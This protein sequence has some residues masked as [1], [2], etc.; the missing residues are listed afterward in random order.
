MKWDVKR[1]KGVVML[2]KGRESER[3]GGV[4]SENKHENKAGDDDQ[5]EHKDCAEKTLL[6]RLLLDAAGLHGAL[7][8]LHAC[9]V[10]VAV[11]VVQK[12]VLVL[13]LVVHVGC[14]VV[15][16]PHARRNALEAVVLLCNLVLRRR[17][18]CARVGR[19]CACSPGS[20]SCA[21][22]VELKV[23]AQAEIVLQEV[24]KRQKKKQE[25][26]VSQNTNKLEKCFVLFPSRHKKGRRA[27]LETEMYM[28]R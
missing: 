10:D 24:G 8:D 25:K 23:F 2:E 3:W 16:D 9:G 7:A 14:N 11:N 5:K 22:S 27:M 28:Q 19:L 18:N 13:E 12:S 1:G 15:L 21:H 20:C 17:Q 26:S 6:L 4:C